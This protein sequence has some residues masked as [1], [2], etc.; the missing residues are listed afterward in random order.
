MKSL[1]TRKK[2][3]INIHKNIALCLIDNK[4]RER[5]GEKTKRE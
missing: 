5:E 1:N 3:Q 2:R 4:E